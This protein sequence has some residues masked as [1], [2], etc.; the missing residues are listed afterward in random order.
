MMPTDELS[1]L[2]AEVKALKSEI[3]GLIEFLQAMYSMMS[4]E[5]EYDEPPTFGNSGFGRYN[6]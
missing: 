6:T 2:K 5:E 1:A 4:E 3:A